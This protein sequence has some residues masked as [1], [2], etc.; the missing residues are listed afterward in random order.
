[1][2]SEFEKYFIHFFFDWDLLVLFGIYWHGLG[3]IGFVWYLLAWI[4]VYW[5]CLGFIGMDWDL[6]VFIGI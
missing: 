1:M 3:F 2:L 4:G 6:L 5:F